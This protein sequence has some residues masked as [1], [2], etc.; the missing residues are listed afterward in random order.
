MS[1][2]RSKVG[3]TSSCGCNG[4][5]LG[6]IGLF[7]T[8]VG[9]GAMHIVRSLLLV[10]GCCRAWFVG[11]KYPRGSQMVNVQAHA[12]RRGRHYWRFIV[13]NL[14][15]HAKGL[16]LPPKICLMWL[17]SIRRPKWTCSCQRMISVRKL[18][19]ILFQPQCLLNI[20]LLWSLLHVQTA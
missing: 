14:R 6:L 1:F 18:L 16:S 5:S 15:V 19:Y 9:A 2:C 4:D 11:P 12:V 8:R 7:A 10:F 17:F 3:K 20:W 13:C